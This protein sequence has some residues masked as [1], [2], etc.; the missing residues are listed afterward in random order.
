[1]RGY[2]DYHSR[3]PPAKRPEYWAIY[4]E[5]LKLQ[6]LLPIPLLFIGLHA[7]VAD[8]RYVEEKEHAGRLL[9]T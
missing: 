9:P 2:I 6:K 3:R 8:R 4:E 1:M 7:V 5:H